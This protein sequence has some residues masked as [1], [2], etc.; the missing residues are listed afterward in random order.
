MSRS[1]HLPARLAGAA[2]LTLSLAAAAQGITPGEEVRGVLRFEERLVALRNVR[3]I[4]GTGATGKDALTVI[5]R[6]GR[7]E[8]VGDASLAIPAAA[9]VLDL[10][11]HSVFPGLV[12]MHDHLLYTASIH[13]DASGGTPQP[14]G[15]VTQIAYTAPRL[16]LASGV[17]TIR[18]AGSI[19]PALDLNLRRKIDAGEMPGPRIDVTAPFLE[20]RGGL[21]PQMTVVQ[22]PEHARRMVH[23]WAAEGATSF[24]AYMM[25]TEPL[26]AAAIEEAHELGLK[27][28]GHLCA[29]DYRRAA[30][31]GIDNLEH[32][33]VFTDSE[34]VPD[35]QPD[36]CPSGRA[37][38]A[39]WLDLDIASEPVQGLIR[40]LVERRVA[41]T[42]TLAVLEAFVPTRPLLSARQQSMMSPESLRSYLQQR[43]AAATS[44][45]TGLMFEAA[46]RKEM[47]FELAFVRAGGHLMMGA[48]PTGNGGALPGFANLRGV[49]L[50]VEAG[51]GPAEALRIASA[52]GATFLGKDQEIGTIE[53]GK[54][55]DLV[56]VRGNPEQ[57]VADLE[58]VEIVFKD[59][60]AYD[61]VRL[62]ESV[63]GMVGI[64]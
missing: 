55:A 18:T 45:E 59:G 44:T 13:R 63:K 40:D 56:V 48:D 61:P 7:I 30:A 49:Q 9:R 22:D 57:D 35:R 43:A 50:L 24:K 60:Y 14:G 2:A 31:I 12:G 38:V 62:L 26:L 42:S 5:L 29:V 8:A 27:V 51:F 3:V 39:S 52:N 21:F 47:A 17:T 46:L 32:G 54:L 6:D 16:Y 1:I 37:V 28:T 20:G 23:F 15:L 64:R 10:E 19:E 34:F 4:D 11:G 58:K 36:T 41:I 53:P 25:I 33:P